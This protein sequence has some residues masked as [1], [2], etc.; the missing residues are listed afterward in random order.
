[1]DPLQLAGSLLA[2]L[3]LAGLARWLGLGQA[4]KLASE[5]DARG[6]AQEAIDGFDPVRF[7]IDREGRAALLAD[8]AGRILLLKQHG[9]FFAARLLGASARAELA[10]SPENKHLTVHSGER[11]FGSV[12]MEVDDAGAWAE[13]INRLNGAGHG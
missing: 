5:E 3:A 8:A 6:A 4:P 1:M 10:G 7:G 9:N 11:R 12:Q 2:V 13:A